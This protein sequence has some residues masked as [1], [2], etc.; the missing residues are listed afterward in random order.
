MQA[1]C[2]S[3]ISML[4]SAKEKVIQMLSYIGKIICSWF[5]HLRARL[6]KQSKHCGKKSFPLPSETAPGQ[7]LLREDVSQE[8]EED[9]MVVPRQQCLA[10]AFATPPDGLSLIVNVIHSVLNVVEG[11]SSP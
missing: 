9:P 1:V 4:A 3:V 11:L 2:L 6:K 5:P 7:L 10:P 8:P